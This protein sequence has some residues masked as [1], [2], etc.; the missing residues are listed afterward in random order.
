MRTE[1]PAA[2]PGSGLWCLSDLRDHPDTPGFPVPHTHAKGERAT[3]PLT[4]ASEMH[5]TVGSARDDFEHPGLEDFQRQAEQIRK[6][7]TALALQAKAAVDSDFVKAGAYNGSRRY[8]AVDE[9]LSPHHA[10]GLEEIARLAVRY[11]LEHQ[12]ALEELKPSV[13]QQMRELTDELIQSMRPPSSS[14]AAGSYNQIVDKIAATYSDRIE[15]ALR[16][17]R[18]G[19]VGGNNVRAATSTL[20]QRS[21]QVLYAAYEQFEA[22]P[23]KRIDTD[24]AAKTAALNQQEVNDA[25]A[26]LLRLGLIEKANERRELSDR[27]DYFRLSGSGIAEV[28]RL[29]IRPEQGTEHFPAGIVNIVMGNVSRDTYSVAQAGA[30]G[31]HSHAHD[32]TFEQVWQQSG[33]DLAEAVGELARLRA[34]VREFGDGTVDQ[35]EGLGALA[36]AQKAAEG[37]DGPGMLRHLKPIGKWVLSFS[38]KVAVPVIAEL[39]KRL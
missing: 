9:V 32:M 29:L 24:E 12:Y 2:A 34:A 39:M 23:S 7:T 6:R 15:N 14:Q 8:F 13:E 22:N 28:E 21:F 3:T 33:I 27:S 35:D 18:I 17:L 19:H 30:V 38:E 4:R 20:R 36:A 11:H 10:S 37:G 5:M 25:L 16:D 1:L 26:Y 31:P